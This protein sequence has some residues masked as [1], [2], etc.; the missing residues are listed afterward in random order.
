MLHRAAC[1][2]SLIHV[3]KVHAAFFRAGS[4]AYI[5]I[6]PPPDG[7]PNWIFLGMR[8]R[9]Q[10]NFTFWRMNACDPVECHTIA[11]LP[12]ANSCGP[13]FHGVSAAGSLYLLTR[14]CQN[15]SASIFFGSSHSTLVPSVLSVSPPLA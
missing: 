9:P 14:S 5:S 10:W 8:P 3:M 4:V 13:S 15:C 1:A 11:V 7:G 2:A 6:L 12:A